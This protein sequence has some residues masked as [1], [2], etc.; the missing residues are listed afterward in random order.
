M[1][2][3]QALAKKKAQ[4]ARRAPRSRALLARFDGLKPKSLPKEPMHEQW[5]FYIDL[6]R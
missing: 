4:V 1:L 6:Q 3:T 2:D 5:R